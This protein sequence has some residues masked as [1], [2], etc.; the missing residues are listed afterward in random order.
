MKRL[1]ILKKIKR[2]LYEDYLPTRLKDSLLR[3]LEKEEEKTRALMAELEE[4]KAYAQGLQ[5]ALRYQQ[6]TSIYINGMKQ[7]PEP[8]SDFE[9]EHSDKNRNR[10]P[11]LEEK[12]G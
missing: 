5:T 3:D 2:R 12:E 9:P 1:H 4:V 6:R 11:D 8:G 10:V 7:K